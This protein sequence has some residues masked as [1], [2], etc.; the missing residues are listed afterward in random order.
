[1]VPKKVPPGTGRGI[2][3]VVVGASGAS[4]SQ[5]WVG[6]QHVQELSED[7]ENG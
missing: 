3:E 2:K 5:L 6:S 4:G 7:K 1:M